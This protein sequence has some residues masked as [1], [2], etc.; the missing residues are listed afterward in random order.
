LPWGFRITSGRIAEIRTIAGK[1]YP[2]AT[3]L[4]KRI[5]DSQVSFEKIILDRGSWVTVQALVLHAP[6]QVPTVVPTGKIAGVDILQVDDLGSMDDEHRDP[7]MSEWVAT[8]AGSSKVQFYRIVGYGLGFITIL[9]IGVIG[10][11]GIDNVSGR[12]RMRRRR[13]KI[14]EVLDSVGAEEPARQ[15]IQDIYVEDSSRGSRAIEELRAVLSSHERTGELVDRYRKKERLLEAERDLKFC[16]P[17]SGTDAFRL[18]IE[19][20]AAHISDD[21]E[22]TVDNDVRDSLSAVSQHLHFARSG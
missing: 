7:V 3:L 14:T 11:V 16:K 15:L 10:M 4:P 22:F 6:N 2:R 8:F 5:S 19:A 17:E 21:G 9:I 20:G 18:L 1:D 12:L 13:A